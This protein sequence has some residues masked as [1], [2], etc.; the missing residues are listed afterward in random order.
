MFQ[1][2]F[3]LFKIDSSANRVFG[4]D[5]LRCVAILLVVIGHF[6]D[7]ISPNNLTQIYHYIAMDGVAVFLY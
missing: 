6:I 1:K 2:L 4:L 3:K 7:S 5:L